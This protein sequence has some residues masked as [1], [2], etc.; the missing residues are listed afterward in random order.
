MVAIKKSPGDKKLLVCKKCRGDADGI[1]EILSFAES[2]LKMKKAKFV[3]FE[4]F[5]IR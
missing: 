4:N 2:K 3:V 5:R 1:K